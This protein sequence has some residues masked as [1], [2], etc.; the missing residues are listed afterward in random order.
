MAT[1]A[2][3][4]NTNGATASDLSDQ[5]E[6]LRADLGNLTQVMADLGKAKGEDAVAAAR[7]AASSARDKVTDQAEVAR[8]QA[9]DLQGQANDF[10]HKQPATAL[11]IAAGLGFLIGFMGS[12]K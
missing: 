4:S 3:Q 11:G 10:I 12:R 8:Q 9:A 7:T 1:T 2:K 5:I 6:I